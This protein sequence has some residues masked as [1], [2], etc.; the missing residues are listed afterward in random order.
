[1][2][3]DSAMSTR[4]LVRTWTASGRIFAVTAGS[5]VAFISLM[6]NTPIHVASFRGGIAFLVVRA[7]TSLGSWLLPRVTEPAEPQRTDETVSP[8]LEAGE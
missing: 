7:L 1:M 3:V 5:L 4:D 2:K 8:G 6:A